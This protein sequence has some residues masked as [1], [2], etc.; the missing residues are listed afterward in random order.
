[1]TVNGAK[2]WLAEYFFHPTLFSAAI[3]FSY[4]KRIKGFIEGNGI[5]KLM[6][7]RAKIVQRTAVADPRMI[8]G[9]R[10]ERKLRE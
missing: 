5:G 1:M 2:K 8:G 10:A 9:H 3:T 7:S 4:V 6:E